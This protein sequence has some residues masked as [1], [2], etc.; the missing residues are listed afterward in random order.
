MYKVSQCLLI[1]M[2]VL[3]SQSHTVLVVEMFTLWW[4]WWDWVETPHSV[5]QENSGSQLLHQNL[6]QSG[7]ASSHMEDSQLL[8]QHPVQSSWEST[9]SLSFPG[10]LSCS[11]QLS[12]TQ[13]TKGWTSLLPT[14][15]EIER[16]EPPLTIIMVSL[17]SYMWLCDS[18]PSLL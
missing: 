15:Y 9:G 17:R 14:Q 16:S 2:V 7:C 6:I 3:V 10:E 12:L 18:N 5:H 13:E 11:P 4:D 1:M 8:H